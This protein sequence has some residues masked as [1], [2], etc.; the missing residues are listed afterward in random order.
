MLRTL[1]TLLI[2]A[3]CFSVLSAAPSPLQKVPVTKPLSLGPATQVVR[4]DAP[5][6]DGVRKPPPRRLDDPIGGAFLG[7]TT[8]YDYQHNSTCGKMIGQDASGRI[9]INWMNGLTEDP[10]GSRYVYYNV[11]DPESWSFIYDTV[12]I[13]VDAS[14]RAGFVT[15][16]VKDDGFC[17]PA[18]HQILTEDGHSAAAIDYIV[19]IDAFTTVEIPYLGEMEIIFP[20]IAI[21]T[22]GHLHTVNTDYG[23]YRVYYA[24]GEPIFDASGFGIDIEWSE[25]QL[26]DTSNFMGPDIA[27]SRHSQRVAIAY[28]ATK[29]GDL[30]GLNVYLQVSEDAG[31]NWDDPIN[32]TNFA[33]PDTDCFNHGGEIPVCNQDT[34][35]PWVDV[36]VFFDE[37][38]YIHLAWTTS[39]WFYWN[40]EGTPGGW[41][42]EFA[43]QIYHWCEDRH[44]FNIVADGFYGNNGQHEAN[45]YNCQRPNLAVDPLTDYLYCS[46]QLYDTIQYSSA[47]YPAADAWVTV[48]TDNGRTW[49][50]AT[51]VSR[52]D[53]GA[54]TP[55]PGSMSETEITVA[56]R[57][58]EGLLHMQYVIDH[59]PGANW[60]GEGS[61]TL[62][63]V[64]YQRIP[65]DSIPISPV[66]DPCQ[67]LRVDSTG[68]P[69]DLCGGSSVDDIA[70]GPPSEFLLYQNYPNPFNPAT[71]IQFDLNRPM[72]A[73]LKVYNVVGQEVATLLN[74]EALSAGV[75]KVNFDAS[76][77]PSGVYIY[78]L[79]SATHAAARKMILL[80]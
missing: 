47:G 65:I 72:T 44:E 77:L 40:N 54:A 78:R 41:T 16:A 6:L 59:D 39:A 71:M 27:A 25:F 45:A 67:A 56:S 62:N 66:I 31:E 76:A 2:L 49:A 70:A 79:T 55:P 69:W 75:H 7:G 42:Y 12:G 10:L 64:I 28:L 32:V 51:N 26:V 9:A 38:D 33:P 1:L 43:S 13:R 3:V 18:F 29:A 14:T 52:T 73:T 50:V 8:Y 17:F 35:R 53:G 30:G 37:H 5:S 60:N 74:E 61:P 68:Y 11:W 48:S 57:V 63:P 36:H 22:S 24:D 34:L 20:H 21:D 46:F 4:T 23:S 58:T 19:Y 80:K 15:A